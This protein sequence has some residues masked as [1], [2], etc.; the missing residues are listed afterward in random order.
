MSL[1]QIVIYPAAVLR[2]K[3]RP[4]KRYDEH[5]MH[6]IDSMFETMSEGNGIGLA[7][8]QIGKSKKVIVVDTMEPGGRHA[9][10][11]PKTIWSSKE[12]EPF[13][14]GCLSLPGV[15]GYVTRPTEVRVRAQRPTD[16]EEL[17]IHADGILARVLQH[18]IDHLNGVLFI[19]YLNDQE[20]LAVEPLLREMEA[21]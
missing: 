1:Q 18:E 10:V 3:T 11:N 19:D 20:R 7:A 14:E 15:E 9:L 8:P 13:K 6:L 2:K 12:R 16:G 21:A 17:T 4:I 5:L